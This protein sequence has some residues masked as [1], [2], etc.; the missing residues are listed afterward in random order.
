MR[1]PALIFTNVLVEDRVNREADLHPRPLPPTKLHQR[2]QRQLVAVPPRGSPDE[3]RPPI[4]SP[5]FRIAAKPSMIGAGGRARA[6]VSELELLL[7]SPNKGVAMAARGA[8]FSPAA[9][10]DSQQVRAAA[11]RALAGDKA[12]AEPLREPS[13][14]PADPGTSAGT[15]KPGA[16]V[17]EPEHPI[18][19]ASPPREQPPSVP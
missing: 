5:A 1:P 4:A 13:A 19:S 2:G 8:L 15:A 12:I 14:P 18:P 3:A 9:S 7:D 11:G 10:D 17:E 16:A 6:S